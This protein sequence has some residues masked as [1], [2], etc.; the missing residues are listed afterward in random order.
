M[1]QRKGHYAWVILMALCIIVGLGKSNINNASGLF[2]AAVSKDLNISVGVLSVYLSIAGIVTLIFLPIGGKIFSKYNASLI[3]LIAVVMQAGAFALFGL[4]NTVWGWYLLSIPLAIGGVIITIVGGPVLIERW[5]SKNKGLALGILTAVAGLFGAFS[6]PIIGSLIIHKGWR[7][8]YLLVGLFT[9]IVIAITIII[10]IKDDPKNKN[11]LPYGYEVKDNV[12]QQSAQQLEGIS[13]SIA[14]K[15]PAFFLLTLFF[16]IITAIASF[17]IHIPIYLTSQGYDPSKVGQMMG[18]FMIGIFV[19]SLLFGFL[20]DKIGSK[21]VSLLAMVVGLIA[22]ILL[23]INPKI[24]IMVMISL[25]LFGA[26][27]SSVGTIS[28]ALTSDLFGSKDYGKIY[29][30]SSIGLALASIIAIP[31]YG[32][33]YDLT[34]SY[35]IALM[36]IV[37][38]FIANMIAIIAAFK[39]KQQLVNEGYWT[40][41]LE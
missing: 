18:V 5:F 3:L 26:F 11:L 38:L 20:T 28:P 13:L 23:M 27:S 21:K 25:F 2:I 1:S 22:I 15:T 41:E 40:T 17:T 34:H 35:L 30:S 6:Q 8:S 31:I 7:Q 32:F 9:L 12:T 37:V 16:F 24:V 36:I 10:F 4:M 14:K 29:A 33:I 19:G 39:N